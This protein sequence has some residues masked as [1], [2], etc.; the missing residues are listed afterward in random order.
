MLAG[1][2]TREARVT[3]P[4]GWYPDG[5]GQTR[6]W[7]GQQWGATQPALATPPAAP[8]PP[9]A[10]PTPPSRP[11]QKHKKQKKHLG[12]WIGLG[13]LALI[14]LI[15]II[16]IATSGS[17]QPKKTAAGSTAPGPTATGQPKPTTIS[18]PATAKTSAA[19][20]TGPTRDNAGARLTTLGSGT[21]TVGTDIPPGRYV[22]TAA[23]GETGN[24]SA[25][26]DDDPVAIDEVL[27]T[28]DGL[29]VASVTT[30]LVKNEIVKIADL[31]HVTFTP[32][33]TEL[34]T[35]LSAGEW[36][37]GLDIAPGRYVV[38][39]GSGQSGNFVVYDTTG[40]PDTDEVLGTADGLGVPTVTVT[41]KSGDTIDISG[42]SIVT[43]AAK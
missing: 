15:V 21:F 18:S 43:F 16:A 12:R 26:T 29:G 17:G 13:G 25:S 6:Y 27:G 22:I 3:T 4:A 33:T 31:A 28:A 42:L 41:L 38:T 40:F 30:D 24:I 5:T 10:T 7:D 34:R 11:P 9:S 1:S 37:V 23:A 19:K 20:P 39:P 35:T 8:T 14:V 2:R 32:A 36:E